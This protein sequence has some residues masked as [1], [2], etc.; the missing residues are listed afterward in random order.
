M[1][2]VLLVL[3]FLI[4]F[5]VGCTQPAPAPGPN[6]IV[7]VGCQVESD[8]SAAFAATIAKTLTCADQ[9]AIQSDVLNLLGKANLC[10]SSMN[11]LKL[12]GKVHGSADGKLKGV[13]GNIV[14]PIAVSAVMGAA[15]K[16]VP[17]AWACAPGTDGNALSA[18]LTTTCTALVTY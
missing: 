1:R 4:A 6:P 18:A 9:S 14:C 5:L 13:V 16:A 15:G 7:N 2:S 8:L 17:T 12:E 3:T 11:Q 10:A